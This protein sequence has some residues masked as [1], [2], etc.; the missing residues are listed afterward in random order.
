MMMEIYE[1]ENLQEISEKIG[2]SPEAL[3]A[4]CEYVDKMDIVF[5]ARP[6]NKEGL[7]IASSG[8]A[9]GKPSKVKDKTSFIGLV[10]ANANFG[11]NLPSKE[12]VAKNDKNASLEKIQAKYG[13]E[14]G[15][16]SLSLEINGEKSALY[17]KFDRNKRKLELPTY[18]VKFNNK[19]IPFSNLEKIEGGVLKYKIK[20]EKN[21][22]EVESIEEVKFLTKNDKFIA[23][24]I[25][26][27]ALGIREEKYSK[28]FENRYKENY[29]GQTSD[30]FSTLDISESHLVGISKKDY[31]S[32][33]NGESDVNLTILYPI[34]KEL[35][36]LFPKTQLIQHMQESNHPF[37]PILTKVKPIE[38]PYVFIFKNK[39]N[40]VCI[41]TATT[42]SEVIKTI[43]DITKLGY[44]IDF[45]PLYGWKGAGN[46]LE[47]NNRR[48]SLANLLDTMAGDGKLSFVCDSEAMKNTNS[49]ELENS[50]LNFI[51]N[52]YKLDELLKPETI[53]K[54]IRNF[55]EKENPT[56]SALTILNNILKIVDDPKDKKRISEYVKEIAEKLTPAL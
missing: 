43:N 36:G 52:K 29:T 38:T 11:K 15:H 55:K 13:K 37:V 39:Q 35:K 34:I 42:E 4:L 21:V 10:P 25:D 30:L 18:Y 17:A 23:G 16:D 31:E 41:R 40:E 14:W 45:N 19:F 28:L 26:M 47:V 51:L 1:K 6:S 7:E 20:K 5:S 53:S 22:S 9:I 56:S 48:A 33:T 12:D 24:D 54:I 50:T 46:R 44:K 8:I 49:N 2:Y 3:K 32:M 27:L